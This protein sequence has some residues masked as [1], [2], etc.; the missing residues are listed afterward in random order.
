[1]KLRELDEIRDK[2]S[3]RNYT[4]NKACINALRDQGTDFYL[5]NDLGRQEAFRIKEV[6][7]LNQ[8]V[9]IEKIT[10]SQLDFLQTRKTVG[11]LWLDDYLNSAD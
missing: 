1:M 9:V 8:T 5:L 10:D 4:E 2:E 3:R 6:H 7:L 11:C